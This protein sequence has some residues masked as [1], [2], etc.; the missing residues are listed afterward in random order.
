MAACIKKQEVKEILNAN[1]NVNTH[2][3]APLSS[4]KPKAQLIQRSHA[5]VV[6]SQT[7]KTRP[8][9]RSGEKRKYDSL[10]L[11]HVLMQEERPLRDA[12]SQ[13][14]GQGHAAKRARTEGDLLEQ[15]EC[16][17]C[18]FTPR[19]GAI[20][21]C[22]NGHPVCARCHPRLS[23]CPM[24]RSK[25]FAQRNRLAERMRET[26]LQTV[27]IPCANELTGCKASGLWGDLKKHENVCLHREVRCPAHHRRACDW[28][29]S[30]KELYIH[31][32]EKKCTQIIKQDEEE[33]AFTS[34]IG[35]FLDDMTV[36]DRKSM[37]HWKPVMLVTRH[38][39]RLFAYLVMSRAPS[40]E[41][42]FY[43][44][45]MA[46][47][48]IV[49]RVKAGIVVRSPASDLSEVKV[50]KVGEVATAGRPS[51][52]E[53]YHEGFVNSF[54]ATEDEVF[55]SGRYLKLSDAEVKGLQNGKTLLEYE[56][57][58]RLCEDYLK[59]S[60][61]SFNNS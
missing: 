53:F 23:R 43:V 51:E 40:G 15:L 20:Y 46:G 36:F 18:R 26:L 61:L 50:G 28:V 31:L 37:T 34:V 30:L 55:K 47:K 5:F 32:N 10:V 49:E 59:K 57:D 45:V 56:V 39:F 11:G 41:W 21:N 58:L 14:Q 60:P 2:R 29:G 9:I 16:S 38:L 25:S 12:L 42:F 24:C 22:D 17:A 6:D 19:E 4:T 54:E 33:K 3:Q 13:G 35:D 52:A 7:P 1:A 27:S 8:P 44:R 48:E